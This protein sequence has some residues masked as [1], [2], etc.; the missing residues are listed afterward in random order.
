MAKQLRLS[1]IFPS[2]RKTKMNIRRVGIFLFF[3]Q[4]L[5]YAGVA[6]EL[7]MQQDQNVP[8]IKAEVSLVPVDVTVRNKEG[9]FVD[10]LQAKDFVVYDNGVAQK[11]DIFSHDE[12]PLDVALVV[13]GGPDDSY[14]LELHNA[15]MTVLQQLNP[16]K[17]RV[18]LFS[19]GN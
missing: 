4:M 16:K 8:A 17:D 1:D 10:N 14:K 15:A 3:S 2:I 6:T 12:M 9:S 13:D 5:L 18:A 11:I 19:T 7:P